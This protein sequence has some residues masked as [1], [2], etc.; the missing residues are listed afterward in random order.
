MDT[1]DINSNGQFLILRVIHSIF[2]AT[3]P[4][5]ILIAFFVSELGI[6]PIFNENEFPIH[7]I[8]ITLGVITIIA[9]LFAY[10]LSK[11]PGKSTMGNV[12][13]AS[14]VSFHIVRISLLQ[15]IAIY[16]LVLAI[17]GSLWFIWI[18]FFVVSAAALVLTLPTEERI[19]NWIQN[20]SKS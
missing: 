16:G 6:G 20:Q 8:E 15:S 13:R 3:I 1:N 4:I 19:R 17:L 10:Y 2:L 14:I 7:I 18:W 9:L 5:F 12:S 11:L